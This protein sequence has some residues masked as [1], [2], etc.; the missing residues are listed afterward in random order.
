MGNA[1]SKVIDSG[2]ALLFAGAIGYVVYWAV[3]LVLAVYCLKRVWFPTPERL[4]WLS[5]PERVKA[6][7]EMR[8]REDDEEFNQRVHRYGYGAYLRDDEKG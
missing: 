2:V 3:G 7:N 1:M 8:K 4:R 5:S 6:L